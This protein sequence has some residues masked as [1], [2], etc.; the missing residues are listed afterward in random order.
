M[1]SKKSSEEFQVCTSE[2]L[3]WVVSG[4]HH[5]LCPHAAH[6]V[7]SKEVIENRGIQWLDSGLVVSVVVCLDLWTIVVM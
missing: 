7:C 4:G 6:L 3:V 2:L 5:P 1:K